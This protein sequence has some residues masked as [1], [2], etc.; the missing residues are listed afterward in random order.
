[1][2]EHNLIKATRMSP[3]VDTSLPYNETK[4]AK[5]TVVITGGAQGLGS[6][7]ARRWA[8]LG[9][10]IMVG[11]IDDKVGEAFVAELR[12]KHPAGSHHY[13]H[14]DVTDWDSQTAFF[15]GAA[16]AS[17]HGGI[18]I[19]VANAGV[20][21]PKANAQFESPEPRPDD[22]DAPPR[23]DLRILEVNVIA[24]MLT[25][26]LALFWLP[27]NGPNRL[28]LHRDSGAAVEGD[29]VRDRCLI[30]VGSAAGVFPFGGQPLYTCSK[31]AITG[32]FR[33]LRGT[34]WA[35]GVRINM[36]CPYFVIGSRMFP[37]VAEAVMLAGTAGG[38][39]LEDVVD[40]ATR[41]AA[42]NAIVGRALFVGPKMHIPDQPHGAGIEDGVVDERAVWDCYAEDYKDSEPFVWRFI[43]GMNAVERVKGWLGFWR[44]LIGMILRMFVGRG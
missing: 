19:V 37:P 4:V 12:A 22:P 30:L 43:R 29:A 38:A 32:I 13:F 16:K 23:P 5:K 6:E 28:N 18:D 41:F 36:L 3:P 24:A 2:A 14:C 33:A 35:N 17:P 40:A 44:E 7:F 1:M 25:A 8:S 9:A 27:R 21:I 31:H 39:R 20:N 10:N 26:H 15:K 34:A 11:D 42:D